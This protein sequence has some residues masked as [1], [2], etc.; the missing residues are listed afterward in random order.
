MYLELLRHSAIVVHLEL[1]FGA[2][3]LTDEDLGEDEQ[4]GVS[5]LPPHTHTPPGWALRCFT[6]CGGT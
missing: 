4:L 6:R 1:L 3:G 5:A 2:R